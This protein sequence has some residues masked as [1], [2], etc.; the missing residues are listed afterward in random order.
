MSDSRQRLAD[1]FEVGETDLELLLRARDRDEIAR[2]MRRLLQWRREL[3]ALAKD[4]DPVALHFQNVR[5]TPQE[6]V[7]IQRWYPELRDSQRGVCNYVEA[8]L[9]RLNSYLRQPDARPKGK[10]GNRPRF[11]YGPIIKE[12]RTIM[13]SSGTDNKSAAVREAAEKFPKLFPGTGTFGNRIKRIVG[14]M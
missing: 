3:I 9:V 10:G 1:H 8:A 4:H 2:L 14:K 5:P 6:T 7:R 12:T 11:D 13:E